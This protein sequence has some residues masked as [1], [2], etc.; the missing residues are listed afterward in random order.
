MPP[1]QVPSR[2][3][4]R[5]HVDPNQQDNPN[6]RF[7]GNDANHVKEETVAT[8]TNLEKDEK[9]PTPGGNHS[10][11]DRRP[12]DSERRVGRAQ[13]AATLRLGAEGC[14]ARR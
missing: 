12:G 9:N 2:I 14:R 1:A 7:A 3:A 8:Q 6:A 13:G 4:V 5:Q 10:G 11:P